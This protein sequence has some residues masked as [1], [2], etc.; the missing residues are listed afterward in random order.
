MTDSSPGPTEDLARLQAVIAEHRAL[1]ADNPDNLYPVFADSLMG[2]AVALAEDGHHGEALAAAEEGVEHFRHLEAADP[3]AFRVH[4]ASALNNFS[5]RLTD[6][7][8]DDDAR[9]ACEESV[10]M[11]SEALADPNPVQA[12]FVLVSALMN[13]SGRSW[14]MGEPDRAIGEMEA[15]VDAFRDGGEALNQFLGVMVDAL[16]KNAMAL[17]EANRW[18][19]AIAIRR[20]TGK[21]FPAPT[22]A[23]V[24][25]LLALTLEHAA[26]AHSRAGQPGQSLPLVE[27]AVELSRGLAQAEPEQYTLFL[28]QSL[29]NM[30]SRQFEAGASPQALEAAL[31]AIKLYQDAAHIN[32]SDTVVPLAMTL[33]TFANILASLGHEE[34]AR[35]VMAQRD[36]LLEIARQVEGVDDHQHGDGCGCGH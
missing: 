7:E 6:A 35:T 24:S 3:A 23:P 34:Q 16:H 10:R 29:S 25:H 19:E 31:E 14:R 13:Q 30:A 11:A 1:M 18:D 4:L 33:E 15:A 22:P 20:M 26:F 32:A 36:E 9:R 21:L 5:N 17:A 28:A 12:R 8:R 27:E 2:L